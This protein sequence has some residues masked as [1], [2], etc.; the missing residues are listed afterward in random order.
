MQ[1]RVLMMI[2][3]C[4]GVTAIT[5]HDESHAAVV[6]VPLHM[7]SCATGNAKRHGWTLHQAAL[8]GN[9]CA[10]VMMLAGGTSVNIGGQVPGIRGTALQ[11]AAREGHEDVVAMLLAA[12]AAV[13]SRMTS[14][15]RSTAL[16][17]AVG[18]LHEGVVKRLLA[19]G[20]SVD[21]KDSD[22]RV[23]LDYARHRCTYPLRYWDAQSSSPACHREHGGPVRAAGQWCFWKEWSGCEARRAA[24]L[25]ML[26][27]AAREQ[28]AKTAEARQSIAL[29]D[30]ALAF[31]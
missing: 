18:A 1:P 20:A 31:S 12:G 27:K 24:V 16:H 17:K 4:G 3:A 19:A 14:R 13:N 30:L 15:Y 5:L 6:G 7:F 26:E 10:A 29:I 21:T 8:A 9:E 2:A 28:S 25:A 11:V 22:G 23:A